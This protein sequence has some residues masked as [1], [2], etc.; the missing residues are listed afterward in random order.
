[1]G[2]YL[3]VFASADVDDE[4]DGVEVG[5]YAD[6]NRL[7]EYVTGHLEGKVYGARFPTLL[8]HVDSDGTWSAEEAGRLERELREIQAE[9]AQ[10]P[11]MP[12]AEGWQQDAARR[13][14]VRPATLADSFIDVD[15]EPLLDRLLALAALAHGKG[16]DIWFQ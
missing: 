9:F 4:L 10:L 6:F 2:L 11:P 14:G 5:S 1:M 12:F 3:A 7:R 13:L 15:G 8:M 16:L